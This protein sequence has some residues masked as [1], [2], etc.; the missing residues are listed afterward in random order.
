MSSVKRFDYSVD[1]GGES[2][3]ETEHGRFVLHSTYAAKEQECEALEWLFEVQEFY[4]LAFTSRDGWDELSATYREARE[5]F[6]VA[7]K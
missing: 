5:A 1:V 4:F 7:S 2:I 6:T 3:V